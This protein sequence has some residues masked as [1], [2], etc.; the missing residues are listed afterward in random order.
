MIKPAIALALTLV[1]GASG[2]F[3]QRAQPPTLQESVLAFYV[4]E[5]HRLVNVRP[6]LFDMAYPI[7]KGFVQNRFDLTS[8]RQEM[9]EQ[10]R[11]LVNQQSSSEEDMKRVIHEVDKADSDIQ[12]N[13]ERF[14]AN[15]DP[16]LNTRQQARVRIFQQTVDRGMSQML[17]SIRNNR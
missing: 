9:L 3:Q 14:L 10:L 6:A 16:L 7:I 13:Q 1:T 8:R 17:N 2:L 11:M 15:I 4:A 5:F 12:A